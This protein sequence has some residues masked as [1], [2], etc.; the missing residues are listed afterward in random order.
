[1]AGMTEPHPCAF[2]GR[3]HT[4][5]VGGGGVGPVFRN[6]LKKKKNYNKLVKNGSAGE[7]LGAIL[8]GNK[9][10]AQRGMAH[11]GKSVDVGFGD[12]RY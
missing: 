9:S 1:M 3:G 8:C 7:G 6:F 2:A 4:L 10:M 11:V 5:W 12:I